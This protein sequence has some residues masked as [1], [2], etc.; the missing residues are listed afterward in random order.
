MRNEENICHIVR[1]GCFKIVLCA[2]NKHYFLHHHYDHYHRHH[3]LLTYSAQC[4][5]NLETSHLFCQ[6]RFTWQ[7]RSRIFLLLL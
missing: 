5:C 3:S 6:G 1:G 2:S 4:S 7:D